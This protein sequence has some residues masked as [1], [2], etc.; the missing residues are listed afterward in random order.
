MTTILHLHQAHRELGRVLPAEAYRAA[1]ALLVIGQSQD[2]QGRD[3]WTWPRDPA[4]ELGYSRRT[5]GGYAGGV[6]PETIRRGIRVLEGLGMVSTEHRGYL[7]PRYTLLPQGWLAAAR[8]AKAAPRQLLARVEQLASGETRRTVSR[9]LSFMLAR[10]SRE[11]ERLAVRAFDAPRVT[12]PAPSPADVIDPDPIP[13]WV[14]HWCREHR[15][16]PAVAWAAAEAV[17]IAQRPKDTPAELVTI[18]KAVLRRWKLRGRPSGL[19][20]VAELALLHSA[21][22]AGLG[23]FRR[24]GR[25]VGRRGLT[26]LLESR[27]YDHL[28]EVATAWRLDQDR[29]PLP[30]PPASVAGISGLTRA[31][32]VDQAMAELCAD[33]VEL[34]ME[35]HAR[36]DRR[37][38]ELLSAPGPAPP[39]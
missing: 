18:G 24:V 1:G 33:G 12:S 2:E 23:A 36:L 27:D 29:P 31:Q 34:S 30:R 39:S 10:V 26:A 17:L 32:A 4:S 7:T 5:L 9:S 13:S 8:L 25:R 6:G 22:R 20:L 11:I 3:T 21:M 35:L 15:A 16:D 14:R 37:V 38:A 19:E 28:V